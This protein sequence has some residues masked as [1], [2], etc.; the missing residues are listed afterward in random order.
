MSA[1]RNATRHHVLQYGKPI[2]VLLHRPEFHRRVAL[3]GH[4][5]RLLLRR[6]PLL[7]LRPAGGQGPTG[8][9]QDVPRQED[10]GG[11]GFFIRL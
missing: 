2:Y 7:L 11:K 9:A 8:R 4:R 1:K 3:P 5:L 10:A 6:R